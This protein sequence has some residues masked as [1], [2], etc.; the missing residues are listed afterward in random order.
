LA[1]FADRTTSNAEAY[2]WYL[3]GR[4]KFLES[5]GSKATMRAA[6]RL[7]AKA[8]EIDPKYA[9][10]Y[11]GI[12]GCDAFLWVAGD[13]DISYDSM[14]ANS[15]TAL[16]L[17]PDLPEAHAAKGVALYATGHSKEASIAFARAI[18]LDPLLYEA[19]FFYGLISKDRGDLD[20]AASAFQ[21]AAAMN[22]EEYGALC[23]LAD[24][25]GAQGRHD[26]SKAVARRGLIRVESI[27]GQRPGTAEILAMGAACAVIVEEYSRAE[28][29]AQ[30]AV[31]LEP[32]NHNARYNVV[33][34]YAVMGK[35]AIAMEHLEHIYSSVPRWRQT[36]LSIM[37]IDTQLNLLRGRTDFQEL[38]ERLEAAAPTT[39][40]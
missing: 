18:E 40:Q 32:D 14:L 9:K 33:C 12:A 36:L 21:T 22:S 11:A 20:K 10:A 29:W 24:V 1:S 28:E 30:R 19:H 35:A 26:E 8:A 6:R 23:L 34:A 25:Y 17:A 39:S 38:Q 4:A 16:Q 13:L 7:F 3:Q 5:F 31:Q 15:D 2:E 37:R 27:L